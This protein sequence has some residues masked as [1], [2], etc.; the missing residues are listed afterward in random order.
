MSVA[1]RLAGTEDAPALSRLGAETFT[2]TFGHLYDPND[3]ALFLVNHGEDSWRQELADP[4]F[5]VLLAENEAGQAIGYAKVGPPPLPF[6]PRGTA[7]ELRQF[8]LLEPF[9]GQGLADQMMQWVIDEA[10]RRGGDDLYLSVFVDNQRARKFY[11]RWGFVAEG[12]YAF[13]VGSH[14]DE[15]VVMR[16]P[17]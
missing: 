9:Q 16:R 3:L 14:A 1:F 15:D 10:E 7:V 13:M 2:E 12:R 11:E 5:A 6:E 8:Y 17:L 4:E